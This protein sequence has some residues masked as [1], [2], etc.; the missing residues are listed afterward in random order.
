KHFGFRTQHK[1]ALKFDADVGDVGE[2]ILQNLRLGFQLTD[3]ENITLGLSEAGSGVQS[4]VLLALHR[5]SQRAAQNPKT[6]FILAVE[7]PEAFLHPQKQKE[8]YDDIKKAQSDNLR[9]LV[10]THSPYIVSETP[11]T[12]LGLVRKQDQHSSLHVPEVADA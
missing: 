6:Q 9:V 8:L 12:K 2:W 7:E 4:G 11:F 10:T 3:D 5:L 1:L